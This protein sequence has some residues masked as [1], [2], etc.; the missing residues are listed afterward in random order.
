MI[1][2]YDYLKN[3]TNYF[4]R[5]ERVEVNE[6][7]EWKV[8]SSNRRADEEPEANSSWIS[9]AA[10]QCRVNSI[11]CCSCLPPPGPKWIIIQLV[12]IHMD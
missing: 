8:S 1:L 2:V 11:I 5:P 4:A 6:V 9:E 12:A 10:A 3:I 7:R